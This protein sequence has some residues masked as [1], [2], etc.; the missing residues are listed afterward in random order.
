MT[1]GRSSS[2]PVVG[3][4]ALLVAVL[5]V[6]TAGGP[7]LPPV[8]PDRWGRWLGATPPV[9]AAFAL[10]RLSTLAAGWYL[11][12]A[13][14]LGLALRL[15]RAPRLSAAADRLT[16]PV[17]RRMLAGVGMA[18]VGLTTAAA[19]QA[20]PAQSP[21]V[22]AAEDTI[23]MR[24]LPPADQAPAPAP[25]QA[26][27]VPTGGSPWTVRSGECF[28]SIADQVLHRAWGRSPTEPEIVPYWTRLI[29]ANRAALAD[30]ANPDLVYPG[31][32]FT[33]PAP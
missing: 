29:A 28:W 10:L 32:T 26:E 22:A 31:Q 16:V 7:P 1:R 18:T 11:A 20:P 6:L 23:T 17:V 9:E 4:V 13:T 24:R 8:S 19:A 25:V 33:V 12:G 5:A 3:W 30:P 21:A 2:W 14:A 15:A 27:P